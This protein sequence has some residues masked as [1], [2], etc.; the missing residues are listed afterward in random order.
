ML[1]FN[2]GD[3]LNLRG[4]DGFILDNWFS[5]NKRAGFAARFEN[6]SITFTANRVEWNHEE[7]M[8]VAGGDGYQITGNFFDR[9]GT[10]GLALRKG[11][12]P[13]KQFTITGISSSAA[14]SLRIRRAM[15]LRRFCSKRLTE[16]LVREITSNAAGTMA[17]QEFGARRTGLYIA[18]WRIV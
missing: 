13:C 10:C 8:V 7:N 16:L 6:A 2:G 4:W 5:G 15:I 3:G 9:A 11:S 18:G 17:E 1:A 14:V 12:R